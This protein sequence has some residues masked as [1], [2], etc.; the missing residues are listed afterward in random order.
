MGY[1][2]GSRPQDAETLVYDIDAD[3]NDLYRDVDINQTIPFLDKVRL[4]QSISFIRDSVRKLRE[5]NVEK[6]HVQAEAKLA[7]L[8]RTIGD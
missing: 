1:Q 8:P 5:L 7:N 6:A 4:L 3:L 2:N